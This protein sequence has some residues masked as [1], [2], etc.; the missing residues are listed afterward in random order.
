[1]EQAC[2]R[3]LLIPFNTEVD[4]SNNSPFLFLLSDHCPPSLKFLFPGVFNIRMPDQEDF[5]ST[6]TTH[7]QYYI[8]IHIY[9]YTAPKTLEFP[10]ILNDDIFRVPRNLNHNA[11]RVTSPLLLPSN[12][13]QSN[14]TENCSSSPVYKFNLNYSSNVQF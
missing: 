13:T 2:V 6:Y 11:V 1:M 5:P 7:T 9:T 12:K 8:H 10:N 14:T 4:E 3:L